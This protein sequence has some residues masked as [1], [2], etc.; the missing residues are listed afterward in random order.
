MNDNG[1]K[2]NAFVT[3]FEAM[4]A[5]GLVLSTTNFQQEAVAQSADDAKGLSD[6][7]I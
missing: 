5:A 2:N 7:G 3:I 4:L 6:I 1:T